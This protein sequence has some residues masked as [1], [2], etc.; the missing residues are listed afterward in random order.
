MGEQW[1]KKLQMLEGEKDPLTKT[2]FF[3]C[4]LTEALKP[5]QIKPVLVGGRA[6]EFYTLGG[7][8]TKDIDLVISGRERVAA[9]LAGMGFLK[10]P[11]ERHW[12]HEGLDLALEIPD[13]LLAGS[14]DRLT[15]LEIAGG[16]CYIIGIEDLVVDRLAAA[17]YWQSLADGQWAA[18]L[19]AL[20]V[21]DIDVDYLHR[22]AANA[23]VEDYLKEVWQQSQAY[24]KLS[25]EQ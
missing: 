3:L 9:V 11:G 12:Y 13:E 15:V 19:L 16:E 4:I 21:N 23:G 7:Y 5:D 14:M 8:A 6:L 22:A 20:H 25:A 1:K 18:K 24:L 2:L 10:R 17:K